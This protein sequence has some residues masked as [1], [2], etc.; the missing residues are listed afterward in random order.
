MNVPKEIKGKLLIVAALLFIVVGFLVV[1]MGHAHA[2][3]TPLITSDAFTGLQTDVL[4]VAAGVIG[5][6]VILAGIGL[7]IAALSR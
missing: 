1:S 5:I 6:A 4:T 7:L 3:W 2:T